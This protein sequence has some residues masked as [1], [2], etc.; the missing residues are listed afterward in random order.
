MEQSFSFNNQAISASPNIVTEIL[1]K[2]GK[3]EQ[4]TSVVVI[5]LD[6]DMFDVYRLSTD[7]PGM[8]SREIYQLSTRIRIEKD[9]QKY[10]A[11]PL[12][13]DGAFTYRMRNIEF[14]ATVSLDAP[15]LT[16]LADRIYLDAD[17]SKQLVS[18]SQEFQS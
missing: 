2:S 16:S 10:A 7:A 6:R 8:W 3:L 12:I 11:P 13:P 9:I 4:K 18:N 17:D 15:L 1:N 5:Y 14:S